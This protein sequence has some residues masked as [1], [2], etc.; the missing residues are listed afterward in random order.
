MK[1]FNEAKDINFEKLLNQFVLKCS[2]DCGGI[3]ICKDKSKLDINNAIEKLKKS[4]A[5][6]YYYEGRE[7]PYKNVVPVVFA[8]E[9][10][11]DEFG[12]LRDYK[13]F[14]FNGQVKALMVGSERYKSE[15]VKQDYFDADYNH[16]PFTKGHPNAKITPNKPGG[17]EKLKDLASELSSG[18]P[19]VRVDLYSINGHPYFG[20]Y[21]FFH[22][23][24]MVEF[25]P[26]EWDYRFG[27]WITLP[28]KRK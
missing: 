20:E 4:L 8:E 19:E 5:K 1:Y 12:E 9:Y 21:T 17:F 6:N 24:G 2:H 3:V 23:G 25:N 10:M 28:Q 18:I 7:W 13:F 11:E 15:E 22:D 14:C 27:E 16:L 26:T